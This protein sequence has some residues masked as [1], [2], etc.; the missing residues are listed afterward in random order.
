[1]SETDTA[2]TH[3]LFDPSDYRVANLSIFPVRVS[4]GT[5]SPP[6]K[7]QQYCNNVPSQK[8]FDE[9]LQGPWRL[10]TGASVGLAMGKVYGLDNRLVC[11]DIDHPGLVACLSY[12]YPSPCARFGSKGIGLF[13]RV[14]KDSAEMK[15]SQNFM[16]HGRG[17]PAVEYLSTGRFTF[18]PPSIHRKT[19][20]VY[21]WRGMPLLSVLDQLPVLTPKDLKIIQTIVSLDVDGA[22]I[23]NLIVGEATHYAALSLAGALVAR[24]LEAERIIR[25]MELLFPRDYTGDT[26]RQIPEMVNSA[27]KKGF[28]KKSER[29]ADATDI[30]DEELDEV[31]AEWAYV[32][33]VNRMVHCIDKQVLDKERFDA[34]MGNR[35]RRAMNLYVQW[36][37]RMVK[38]KLTY[39]PGLPPTTPDAIN[40]WRPT[41]LNPK[42]GSVEFWLDHLKSFYDEAEVEHLLNWL[43]HSLQRPTVKPGHAILMGSKY[44]GIGKDLWLLPVR[45]AYG[46]HNVSEIGADSLSSSFNEWLAHKHLIIIQEIWTGSRR[47]LSNQLKP[48]LSS[49]PDEVMVNEKNVSRYPIP[50]ICATVMLT[51]HKD[52][53][54]MAAEDRRYFVMWSE[55]PPMDADYY[56]ALFDWCNDPESQSH[57]YEYLLRRDIR[58]FNIKAPPPK[59]YA[60]ADMVDATMT[61]QEALVVVIRDILADM[62]LK[63]VI[64][65]Q[66]VFDHLRE[67]APDIAREVIKIPRSSPRY[68]L[69]LAIK[70]LGYETLPIKASKKI[71]GKVRSITVFAVDSKFKEYEEAR[72]V[73]LFDLIQHPVEY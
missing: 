13:Y 38:Q 27:F 16:V 41:E 33:S 5:V 34:L 1:M 2:Q 62:G 60:K 19:G 58:K 9:W 25:A 28:D 42:P 17:S 67:V 68:P 39:L 4:G 30:D 56:Q 26:I 29:P 18:I 47:E 22:T 65:E 15:K 61:K 21:E 32:T 44:E 43:A 73:D 12:L 69:R 48:L 57:V 50:N 46:K 66:P 8:Q 3:N 10:H 24:G 6:E 7:W 37:N 64:A 70:A 36:P 55:R 11:L 51:N 72:P 23:E 31:F 49:P 53:V 45:A 20:K 63:D 52:A 59:T 35:V 71:D 14:D 54:S 40:M